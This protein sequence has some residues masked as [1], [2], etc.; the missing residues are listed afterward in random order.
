MR[1]IKLSPSDPDMPSIEAVHEYFNE[2]LASRIPQ[3]RFLL[4]KGRIKPDG[5]SIGEFVVFTYKAKLVYIAVVSQEVTPNLDNDKDDYPSYFCIDLA[6]LTSCKGTLSEFNKKLIDNHVTDKSFGG[7]GWV[8]VPEAEEN[9]ETE[10]LL[11]KFTDTKAP[12]VT[13]RVTEIVARIGQQKFRNNLKSMWRG[14]A[15]TGLDVDQ[16]L[17][18]SH[19][20]PWKDSNG[21]E[22]LDCYNGLLLAP[23][24]DAAFDKGLITFDKNGKIQISQVLHGQEQALGICSS[25]KLSTITAKHEKYLSWHRNQVF[26]EKKT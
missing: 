1:I 2:K 21:V 7:Q 4:T 19:I 18:A 23:H 24:L 5:L 13:G 20:K 8:Q 10:S 6:T 16:L 25:M 12:T 9:P 17:I 26:R 22:K 14:C 15:V 3:G 11:N